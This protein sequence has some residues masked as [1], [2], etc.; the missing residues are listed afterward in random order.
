V[1]SSSLREQA[2]H[3]HREFE[4]YQAVKNQEIAAL[5]E[6]VRELIQGGASMPAGKA[7]KAEPRV[8]KLTHTRQQRTSVAARKG[9]RLERGAGCLAKK[10]RSGHRAGTPDSATGTSTPSSEC[11][12]IRAGVSCEVRPELLWP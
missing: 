12:G 9:L 7:T 6:R 10:R 8:S 1:A 2:E 5:D 4:E 11:S 3:M